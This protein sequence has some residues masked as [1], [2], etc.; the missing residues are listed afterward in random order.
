MSK[1]SDVDV[2]CPVCGICGTRT[3]AW[4]HGQHVCTT[5]QTIWDGSEREEIVDEFS[6]SPVRPVRDDVITIL[7]HLW[8]KG[9]IEDDVHGH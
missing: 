3:I 9:M 6:M 8:R 7:A 1:S 2:W 5:C 4:L